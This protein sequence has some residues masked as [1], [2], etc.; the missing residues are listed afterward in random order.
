MEPNNQ[1]KNHHEAL[2]GS[3]IIVVIFIVGAIFFWKNFVVKKTPQPQAQVVNN[4]AQ[5]QAD[6]SLDQ[7]ESDLNNMDLDTLDKGI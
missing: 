6:P 1:E 2:I 4:S 5:N 7:T 3:I